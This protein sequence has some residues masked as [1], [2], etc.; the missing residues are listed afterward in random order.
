MTSTNIMTMGPGPI[1]ERFILTFSDCTASAT[2]QTFSLK[3]LPQG[4]IVK[5]VRIK[6]STLFGGG[7]AAVATV[8][9][10]ATAGSTTTFA[11]AFDIHQAVAATTAQMS[12]GWKAATYAAD[13]LTATI[14][15]DV[16]VNTLTAG[17]VNIDVEY[18]L[19]EDLTATAPVGN[20]PASG[21]LL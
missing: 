20:T 11:A 8:S 14:V 9:V 1:M 6:H 16:N 17:V 5:G 13:T 2:T 10:G 7:G 12:S 3:S 18:L 21:G 15:S 4:S 19:A